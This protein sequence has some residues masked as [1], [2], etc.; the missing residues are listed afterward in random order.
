MKALSTQR[1]HLPEALTEG[2]SK[3]FIQKTIQAAR[4]KWVKSSA[5]CCC[6]VGE[7]SMHKPLLSFVLLRTVSE[8]VMGDQAYGVMKGSSANF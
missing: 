3:S 4:I 2:L 1:Y 8:K 6:E 5:K 7:V